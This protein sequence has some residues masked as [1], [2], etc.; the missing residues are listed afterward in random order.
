M[1]CTQVLTRFW[2]QIPDPRVG[3]RN[4]LPQVGKTF[5]VGLST[6]GVSLG[7]HRLHDCVMYSGKKV[8]F[9]QMEEEILQLKEELEKQR[10]RCARL[11]DELD[12][13]AVDN[14]RLRKLLASGGSSDPSGFTSRNVTSHCN[15]SGGGLLPAVGEGE[16]CP[17]EVNFDWRELLIDGDANY[18]DAV[19]H[20]I[21]NACGGMNALSVAF[22][23]YPGEYDEK[24][25][26]K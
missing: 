23:A 22:C 10:S 21:E 9:F 15:N 26:D 11:E 4:V 7:Q 6:I 16:S 20:K 13:L 2:F 12:D 18:A 17:T 5:I 1:L 19:Q 8:R 24:L 14:D 3:E 25:R